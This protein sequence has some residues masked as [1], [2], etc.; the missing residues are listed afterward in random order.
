MYKATIEPSTKIE[1]EVEDSLPFLMQV[2]EGQQELKKLE[3]REVSAKQS[4]AVAG[5]SLQADQQPEQ[6]VQ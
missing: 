4:G 6:E 1:M 3:A 5:P 2:S